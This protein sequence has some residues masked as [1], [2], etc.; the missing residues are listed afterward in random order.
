MFKYRTA[1]L[2]SLISLFELPE[3]SSTPDDEHFIDVEDT[4]SIT[5]NWI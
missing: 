2:E 3:D 1:L 4:S 5:F